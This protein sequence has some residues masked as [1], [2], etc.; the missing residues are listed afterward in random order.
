MLSVI[1]KKELKRVF[2]DRRLVFSAFILP[3]LSIF[4][5]YS[6]MGVMME[7]LQ[8]DI[9]QNI[10][11]VYIQNSPE[12][13]KSF[14]EESEFISE[15]D[16]IYIDENQEIEIIKQEIKDGE[17]DL[18]V[19]FEPDFEKKINE[20]KVTGEIP[21][22]NTYSNSSKE[23]SSYAKNVIFSDL[24][25]DYENL[26]LGQRFGDIN[27]I[28]IFDIDKNNKDKDLA[29]EKKIVGKG[30]STFIPLLI[31][32][33]LFAGAM[34]IGMDSVAGEKE[35]GTMATLLVTPVKREVIALGKII[36]LAIVSVISALSCVVGVVGSLPFASSFLAPGSSDFD[37]SALAFG[38]SDY[39]KL[40]LVLLSLVSI[41]VC[42][43]IILSIIAKTV[44]EAGA[45]VSPCYMVVLFLAVLTGF[46]AEQL[47][48]WKYAIPIYGNISAIKDIFMFQLTWSHFAINFASSLILSSI[49]VYIITKLFNSEKIMMAK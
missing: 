9:V 17:I 14:F 49:L 31:S 46:G 47:V 40:F 38:I 29:D 28:N 11:T 42:L 30:L 39:T 1:I 6:V 33:L 48:S 41:Y 35:R 10:P 25:Y 3:A 21:V 45:Y 5:M 7:E 22:I 44:K 26:L 16:S 19:E 4:I 27:Y 8:D 13:F 24:L 32:I 23:Y 15:V 36:S 37:I 43:I 12:G 20:Y 18:L 34:T 2:T